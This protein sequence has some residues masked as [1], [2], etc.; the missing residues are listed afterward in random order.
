MALLMRQM[1]VAD[2]LRVIA[3]YAFWLPCGGAV[4]LLC[5]VLLL[6]PEWTSPALLHGPNRQLAGGRSWTW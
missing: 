1:A 3:L 6:H 2:G 5:C 4:R